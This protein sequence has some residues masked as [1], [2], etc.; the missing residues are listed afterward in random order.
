MYTIKKGTRIK[1]DNG[2]EFVE[3]EDSLVIPESQR[4]K[5]KKIQ[6]AKKFNQSIRDHTKMMG[7]FTFL[8]NDYVL[9]HIPATVI[10]RLAYLSTYLSFQN[11]L[12]ID[13]DGT[14]MLK[15]DLSDILGISRQKA[16]DFYNVCASNNLLFDHGADGLYINEIF[17][18][19]STKNKQQIRLYRDPIQQLYK[20]IIKDKQNSTQALRH[21]GY[22]VQLIPWINREWNILCSNPNETEPGK[23]IPLSLKE[24]TLILHIDE[25]NVGRLKKTLLKP[26]FKW[27]NEY[28]QLCSCMKVTTDEG[29]QE[30]V[31]VNPNLL[32]AGSDFDKVAGIGV[33]FTKHKTAEKQ[34]NVEKSEK[35]TA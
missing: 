27:N 35:S 33:A 12:L 30:T 5:Y 24:I 11:Q 16:N 10:G 8:Q 28:Q 2:Y 4:Q 34:A 21:F 31:Y 25:T 29:I 32:F 20:T 9:N 26:L 13:N 19:N 22:V 23:I 17:F 7:G 6:E 18:R 14:P 3:D 1:Y 15:R